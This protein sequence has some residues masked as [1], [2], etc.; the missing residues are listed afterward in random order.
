MVGNQYSK[1]VL[2]VALHKLLEDFSDCCYFPSY[3]IV[4]DD[5]RDYRFFESNMTHPN[6]LATEYIWDKFTSV[7]F[8]GKTMKEI[9]EIKGLKQAMEHR[10]FNPRS[11]EYSTFLKTYLRRTKELKRRF[12]ELDFSGEEQFFSKNLFV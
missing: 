6:K 12:P 4:M 7:F 9:E 8:N 1:S 5:L 3:E 10:P 11:D 2:F